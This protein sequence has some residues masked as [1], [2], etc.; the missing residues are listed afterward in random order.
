MKHAEFHAYVEARDLGR[1]IIPPTECRG[2]IKRVVIPPA[3]A[4]VMP[5]RRLY[6]CLSCFAGFG[7]ENGRVVWYEPADAEPPPF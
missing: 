4:A 7:T 2:T 5:G 1:G 6:F 3:D